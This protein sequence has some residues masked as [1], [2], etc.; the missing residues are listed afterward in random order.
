MNFNETYEALDLAVK[1]NS[2]PLI[3]GE[4]GIGKTSLMKK[5]CIDN[6]LELVN[7]DANLL[8]EGEIG[9]LPTVV[10]GRT[11]YAT[12]YKLSK[13]DEILK[14]TSKKVMLFIDEINRSDHS[15]QQELMNLILNREINGYVLD[16]RVIVTSAMNPSGR[17]DEFRD[18]DY[19][20]VEMDSAQQN[21]FVWLLMDSDAKEWLIWGMNE[22]NIHPKVID[23]ISDFE[24]YLHYKND[25]DFIE[26]TPRSWERISNALKIYNENDYSKGA[27][28]NFVKGN[29]G[30]T[31]TQDF[32]AFLRDNHEDTIKYKDLLNL[33]YLGQNI[34]DKLK[35][36]SHSKQY[37]LYINLVNY[38]ES[39]INE[40][41][42]LKENDKNDENIEYQSK[43]KAHLNIVSQVLMAYPKDLRISLMKETR[44]NYLNTYSLLLRED[45]FLEG[46]FDAYE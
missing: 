18:T 16:E 40:N 8:K 33:D 32:I 20:I 45:L 27:L 38:I 21:R 9:G 31:I 34:V 36:S 25:G 11:V 7:I 35:D 5:Y 43:L 28:Y 23:F 6:D 12:H 24:K 26:A 2:V 3:I 4:S 39:F 15:V 37:I 10:N 17:M 41:D 1:S 13:I 44:R 42:K 46:F 19:Q 22:G 29:V 14:K 30:S